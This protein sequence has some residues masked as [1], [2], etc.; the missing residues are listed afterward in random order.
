MV[1]DFPG[2]IHEGNG[3]QQLIIDERAH[4]AQ[5]EAKKT[6]RRLKVYRQLPILRGPCRSTCAGSKPKV[7]LKPS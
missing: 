2:A 1:A 6:F 3:T 7:P 5:R 4:D